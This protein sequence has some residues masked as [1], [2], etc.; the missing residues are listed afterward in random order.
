MREPV[1]HL[2]YGSTKMMRLLKA[3]APQHWKK[4]FCHPVL[5]HV[6][7]VEHQFEAGAVGAAWLYGSGS[8]S[9][10]GSMR[11]HTA[12]APASLTLLFDFFYIKFDFTKFIK[13]LF[14]KCSFLARLGSG[15]GLS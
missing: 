10:R 5:K 15:S 9:T 13:S 6:Y 4:Q 14:F 12:P 3:A 1:P 11:L 8:G 2:G 7:Y